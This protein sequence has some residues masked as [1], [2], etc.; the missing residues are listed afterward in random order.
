M[1]IRNIAIIAHVDHGKTTLTDALMQQTGMSE[2]GD[3]MDSDTQLSA[4]DVDLADAG[5]REILDELEWRDEN[6][7][8]NSEQR[9]QAVTDL[10]ELVVAVDGILQ[11]QASA[12]AATAYFKRFFFQ[13]RQP[14][15]ADQRA[16]Q[17]K[18]PTPMRT[19]GLIE[20]CHWEKPRHP[21]CASSALLSSS[22]SRASCKLARTAESPGIIR[23]ARS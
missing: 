16:S 1:E 9:E 11:M 10:I 5:Q 20:L 19:V 7:R 18:T 22:C 13:Y 4:T 23:A 12:D 14:A 8:L 3:S 6:K 15:A 17:E 2:V 21:D